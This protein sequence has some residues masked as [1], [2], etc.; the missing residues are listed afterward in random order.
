MAVNRY[1]VGTRVRLTCTFKVGATPTDPTA[2]VCIVEEPDA[3]QEEPTVVKDSTGVYHADFTPTQKG[4]H[5][6]RWVG[7]GA[8]EA[9]SEA[10]F[11]ADS[12]VV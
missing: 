11:M 12:R 7:T 6:Y 3:D 2:Q 8:C 10:S 4:E 9:A 1:T 5:I